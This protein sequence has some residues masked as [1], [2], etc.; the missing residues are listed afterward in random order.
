MALTE[1]YFPQ[2]G[3]GRRLGLLAWP[4]LDHRVLKRQASTITMTAPTTSRTSSSPRML[5][6]AIFPSLPSLCRGSCPPDHLPLG[7]IRQA[8]TGGHYADRHSRRYDARRSARR[9]RCH[10]GDRCLSAPA[11]PQGNSRHEKK[12][13]GYVRGRKR[14]YV[15]YSAHI[16]PHNW[17]YPLFLPPFPPR[18]R[19]TSPVRPRICGPIPVASSWPSKHAEPVYQL[20]GRAGLGVGDM[21]PA[22]HPVGDFVG[23]HVRTGEHDVTAYDWEQYLAFADRHFRQKVAGGEWRPSGDGPKLL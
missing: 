8:L 16:L 20:L 12:G 10:L 23:Y 4:E 11:P 9:G 21:P 1:T 22:D 19:S 7:S 15:E 6:R 18:G 3:Q 5:I 13:G 2:S 17:T 14:G